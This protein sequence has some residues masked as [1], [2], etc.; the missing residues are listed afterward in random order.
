MGSSTKAKPH[1]GS[2]DKTPLGKT[3]CSVLCAEVTKAVLLRQPGKTPAEAVPIIELLL[4][5]YK[6]AVQADFRKLQTKSNYAKHRCILRK[7]ATAFWSGCMVVPQPFDWIAFNL[8]MS[9]NA[10]RRNIIDVLFSVFG[11]ETF[12]EPDSETKLI[13]P[14]SSAADRQRGFALHDEHARNVC[15]ELAVVMHA[16]PLSARTLL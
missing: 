3:R 14:S 12:R 1:A 6:N 5:R 9:T 7:Y 16:H 2:T 13:T 11:G 8:S 15:Q 10:W 4:G